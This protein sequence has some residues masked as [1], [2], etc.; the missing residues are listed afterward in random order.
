MIHQE[1]MLNIGKT[2][3]GYDINNE[4]KYDNKIRW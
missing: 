1:R 3:H 4:I 2:V